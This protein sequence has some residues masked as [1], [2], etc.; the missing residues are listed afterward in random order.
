[1]SEGTRHAL[2]YSE[3]LSS[4]VERVMRERQTLGEPSSDGWEYSAKGKMFQHKSAGL[5]VFEC[6]EWCAG[7]NASL[8]RGRS[9]LRWMSALHGDLF[10]EEPF[11]R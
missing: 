4:T 1:M 9:C 8:R 7:L 5:R 3:E 6:H 2:T 11:K 10:G